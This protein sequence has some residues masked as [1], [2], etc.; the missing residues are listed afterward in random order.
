MTLLKKKHVLGVLAWLHLLSCG[1][2]PEDL[3]E[4][5]EREGNL[6]GLVSACNTQAEPQL[7]GLKSA[8][9]YQKEGRTVLQ[10]SNLGVDCDEDLA[11]P[12]EATDPMKK[13]RCRLP[14]RAWIDRINFSLPAFDSL[15]PGEYS[16]NESSLT[17]SQEYQS[18][19]GRNG[20]CLAHSGL[21]PNPAK[22]ESVVI[23]S[24]SPT[25]VIGRIKGVNSLASGHPPDGSI[26]DIRFVAM[27]CR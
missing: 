12:L 20:H 6:S 21:V 16:Q 7:P 1:E 9:I 10:L 17:W 18:V 5:Y 14:K 24:T 13:I 19:E 3:L 23:E 25:C 4:Q 27:R 22:R 2:S 15:A 26:S 8:W 11:V